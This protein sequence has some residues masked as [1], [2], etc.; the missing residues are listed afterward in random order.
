MYYVDKSKMYCIVICRQSGLYLAFG[1][2]VLPSAFL[3]HQDLGN[4]EVNTDLGCGQ[5]KAY[6]I[7]FLATFIKEPEILC[8]SIFRKQQHQYS[9]SC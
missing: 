5:K 8:R 2:P 3:L 7:T 4:C 1:L 9:R 6:V